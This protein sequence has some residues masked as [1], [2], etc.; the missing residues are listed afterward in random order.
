MIQAAKSYYLD[1][2]KANPITLTSQ[3]PNLP[4]PNPT[5]LRIHAA[6]CRVAYLSGIAEYMEETL[7]GLDNIEVLS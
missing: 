7:D 6:C 4:L 1:K 3:Y 5:Y 2:C